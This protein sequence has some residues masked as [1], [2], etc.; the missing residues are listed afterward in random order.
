MKHVS[1]LLITFEDCSRAQLQCLLL[2]EATDGES[3]SMYI[4]KHYTV[5]SSAVN[6][7]N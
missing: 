2:K 4:K 7:A 5:F 1:S 3:V 6:M